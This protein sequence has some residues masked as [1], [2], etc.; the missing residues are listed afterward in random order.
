MIGGGGSDVFL[1]PV[2]P[3][4]AKSIGAVQILGELGKGAHST[5][6]H[7]RRQ[8]DQKQFALKV[9][10]IKDRSQHKFLEQAQHEFRVAQM[11]DHPNLIKVLLLETERDWFWRVKRVRLLIELV[12]GR[13]LDQSQ[14]LTLPRIVQVFGKIA[15]GLM[16]M[17]RR[18]VC[19]ADL[20]PNNILL[21]RTGEVKIIDFGLAWIKTEP[22]DRVQ[23]TPE[24]MAPEQSKHGTVNEATDIY[25][26]GA[27]MYR[28]T[29]WRLPPSTLAA[30]GGPGMNSQLFQSLLKPVMELAPNTP[31]RLADLIHQCLSYNP[32]NRPARVGEIQDVLNSLIEALVQT[33]DDRL[34]AMGW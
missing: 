7:V 17:H 26:F 19:H 5:I 18:G 1:S 33:E 11:F 34:E 2:G 6:Y 10:P 4:M 20:K 8:S 22:K 30:P 32:K 24:Y 25:N 3:G 21:S 12:Q 23:G 14:G 13:T 31:K 28:L 16:H 15:G 9:V 27:T 29:T